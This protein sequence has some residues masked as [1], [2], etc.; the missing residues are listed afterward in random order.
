MSLELCVMTLGVPMK[1]WLSA[2][3]LTSH[4]RVSLCEHSNFNYAIKYLVGT[5]PKQEQS[6]L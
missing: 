2:L 4:H 6:H 3:N 5:C 1:Q